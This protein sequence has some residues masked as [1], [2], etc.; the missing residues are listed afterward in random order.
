VRV[1]GRGPFWQGFLLDITERKHA[2][3]KLE[4]ALAVER[5]ATRSLRA[6]DDM[7]NT[8]LQA[9]SHDLRTPLAAILGLAITLERGDVHLEEADAK[10]LARRIASNAR[11]LDRLVMNLLD[12][13]RLAR[14]IVHPKMAETD[15]GALVRRVVSESELVSDARLRTDIRAH[16]QSV[17]VAKL[18]RIVE[19]MLANAVR[20]TPDGATIWVSLRPETD[21]VLLLVEDDGPGVPAELRESVF[22]PFRQGPDA[23]QYAPGVGVG[24]TLVRRFAELHGGRAWVEEREGGGASFR[25]FLPSEPAPAV[26]DDPG[27]PV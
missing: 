19:N 18:E 26:E 4:R 8:F 2:E 11:R 20:H 5:D 7:K 14:G 25:V 24:L 21:G 16:T 22:E 12:L 3:E 6:L 23:P 27:A 10:D 9:V 1:E 15:V 13:D 17:D